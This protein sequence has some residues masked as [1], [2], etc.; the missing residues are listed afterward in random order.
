MEVDTTDKTG[1]YVKVEIVAVDDVDGHI[2]FGKSPA[3]K[4]FDVYAAPIT[5]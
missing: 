2:I 4:I 3:F 1:R 5:P